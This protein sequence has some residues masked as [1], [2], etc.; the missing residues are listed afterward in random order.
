MNRELL[1]EQDPDLIF[2]REEDLE[3]FCKTHPYTKLTA[4][5]EHRVYPINTG[6]IDTPSPRNMLAIEYIY[7]II[8]DS[9]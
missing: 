6:W 1:F 2:I 8:G 4:V 5:K 7:K 3:T 9:E